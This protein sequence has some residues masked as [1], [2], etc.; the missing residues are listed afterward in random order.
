[1]A[2][3]KDRYTRSTL[4]IGINFLFF[5]LG[6]LVIEVYEDVIWF[7][8]TLVIVSFFMGLLISIGLS[9]LNRTPLGGVIIGFSLSGSYWIGFLTG[10]LTKIQFGSNMDVLKQYGPYALYVSAAFASLGLFFG[11]LGY[12]TEHLFVEN[13]IVETYVFRDYWSNVYN[14]GKNVRREYQGLDQR[15]TR[16][17]L[18]VR[19]WWQQQVHRVRQAKPELMYVSQ[20]AKRWIERLSV[21]R[22][23]V[24]YTIFHLGRIYTRTWLIPATLSVCISPLL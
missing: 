20:V 22:R 19:D 3:E 7:N 6:V 4:M 11:V 9:F 8:Y 5:F 10:L 14:L 21:W 12:F 16:F 24:T 18:T 23:S 1:M 13:P 15:M 2:E 17:H